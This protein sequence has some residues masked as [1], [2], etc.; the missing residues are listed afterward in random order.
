MDL[1]IRVCTVESSLKLDSDQANNPD[2]EELHKQARNNR[3]SLDLNR[4]DS[5][6]SQSDRHKIPPLDPPLGYAREATKSWQ[7]V[8]SGAAIRSIERF[9]TDF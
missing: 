3:S 7:I 8:V 4:P 2:G 9:V 5:R 1:L 6:A